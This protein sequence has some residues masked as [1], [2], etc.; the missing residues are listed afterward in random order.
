MSARRPAGTPRSSPTWRPAETGETRSRLSLT[1]ECAP[2]PI[3]F[4]RRVRRGPRRGSQRSSGQSR[5]GQELGAGDTGHTPPDSKPSTGERERSSP[6]RQGFRHFEQARDR[7]HDNQRVQV[8]E[9]CHGLCGEQN[10]YLCSREGN[11]PWTSSQSYGID[12]PPARAT[13]GTRNAL[14][15]PI[16]GIGLPSRNSSCPGLSPPSTTPSSLNCTS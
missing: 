12:R 4:L 8:Q 6:T 10:D 15:C 11:N 1:R 5:S 3:A 2:Y 13:N 9:P 16:L 7:L 14:T